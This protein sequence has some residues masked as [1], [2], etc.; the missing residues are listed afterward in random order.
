MMFETAILPVVERAARKAFGQDDEKVSVTTCLAW[1][2]WSRR[3]H[4]YAASHWAR[5]AIRD[6]M[7]GRD[8]PGIRTKF[9]DVWDHLVRWQGAGMDEVLDRRPGPEEQVMW[10][11]EYERV[12]ERLTPE[13]QRMA[14]IIRS[15]A[16]AG[17]GDIATRLGK[18]AGRVSQMRREILALL[19]EED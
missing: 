7:N 14:D 6:V 13:Q 10:A 8:V 1:L 4:D 11:E 19:R 15:D 12:C 9:R 2:Y 16:N 18:S 5:L 17:T 3:P